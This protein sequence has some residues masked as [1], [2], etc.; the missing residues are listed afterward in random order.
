MSAD[1]ISISHD[2]HR[3]TEN[4]RQSLPQNPRLHRLRVVSELLETGH[5]RYIDC[6]LLSG[7]LR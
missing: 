6:C 3:Y 4:L 7:D 2:F 5:P 1:P